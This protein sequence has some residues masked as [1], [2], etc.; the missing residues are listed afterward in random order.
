MLKA[1]GCWKVS[2]TFLTQKERD[3]ESVLDQ[4]LARYYSSAQGR[5]TSADEFAGGPDEFCVLGKGDSKKQAY[6][7]ITNP[8]SLNNF[9]YCYNSPLRYVDTDGHVVRLDNQTKA[10][11]REARGRLTFNLAT[12]EKQYFTIN[13]DRRT[14]ANTLELKGI[15][16]APKVE[17]SVLSLRLFESVLKSGKRCASISTLKV[18]L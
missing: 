15:F 8:Q 9:Q 10:D 5:F 3:S 6:A 7:D 12:N 17:T 14:G 1:A 13:H 16:G 4:F 2:C 11:R 18:N